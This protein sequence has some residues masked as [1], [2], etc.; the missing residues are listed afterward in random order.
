MSNPPRTSAGGAQ[1]STGARTARITLGR[2]LK[3]ESTNY[4]V[5]LGLTLFLVALGLV[6]VLSSSS[7]D[8]HLDGSG[9]F[10]GFWRQ[11]TYAIIGVPLMLIVSRFPITFWKKWAWPALLFGMALQLLVFTPLGLETGGNRNWIELGP[12]TAQ[13]SEV[14]KLGLVIWLGLILTVKQDR[15]GDWKHAL[16]PVLP[17]AGLSLGFVLLGGDLGTVM[18][19]AMIVFAALYFAGIRLRVLAIPLVAGIIGVLIMAV[20]SPNRM[21]RIMSFLGDGCTDYENSCW[22]PLHA[23]WA[24]ANG[25][26]FGVGLG[27]SRA[28]WSWLPAASN[29]Y[30]FAVI[31]EELGLIGAVLVLGLFV[32]LTIM[33]IRIIRSTD[34]QFVRV[35]TGAIMTWIIGQALLN[36]GVVLGLFPVLGVPLPFIS[37]GGTALLSTLLSM[38]IVLSFARSRAT[39]ARPTTR[40]RP[41]RRP[42]DTTVGAR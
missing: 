34:D 8:S 32:F 1:A 35:T 40:R 36:I 12:I 22:Q 18:I 39:P 11:G 4:F 25:G 17:I 24:L 33:F 2:V 26:V 31:G 16:I 28:K 14:V 9:Y 21:Q 37:A 3:P 15:L 20:T 38:G 30:I 23:T 19:M 7:V 13:P 10:G 41:A 5:M 6:M 42:A 27:N 29:D